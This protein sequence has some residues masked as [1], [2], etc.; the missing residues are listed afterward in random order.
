MTDEEQVLHE[1]IE[2]LRKDYEKAIEPYLNR[3]LLLRNLNHKHSVI[4]TKEHAQ[5]LGLLPPTT[6]KENE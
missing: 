1:I 2:T 4:L 5:Q 3:L 6:G